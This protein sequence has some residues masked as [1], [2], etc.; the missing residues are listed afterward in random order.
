MAWAV[1]AVSKWAFHNI[2]IFAKISSK[3]LRGGDGGPGG[4]GDI[5]LEPTSISM[6]RIFVGVSAKSS[7]HTY[8]GR[9]QVALIWNWR[10][11]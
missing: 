9:G 4:G 1:I 2:R 7:G 11:L 10:R 3:P 6:A 8:H 5:F